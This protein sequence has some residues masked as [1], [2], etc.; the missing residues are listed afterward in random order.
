MPQLSGKPRLGFTN[1]NQAWNPGFNDCNSTAAMGLQF[2]CS[3]TVSDPVESPN[4]G[5]QPASNPLLQKA[6]HWGVW[7]VCGSSPQGAVENWMETG[8][9]KGAFFGAIAGG[10]A[11]GAATFGLGGVP[12]AVLG[13]FLGGTAGAAGGVIAG[14][15]AAGVCSALGAY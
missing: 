6:K 9:T 12:G 7:Y 11:G 5:T 1:R 8:A 14:G 4:N 3:K 2:A 15:M 10:G 13:G